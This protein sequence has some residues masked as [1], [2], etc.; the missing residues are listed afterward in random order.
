MKEVS[1]NELVPGTMYYIQSERRISGNGK[2][3]GVFT[4]IVQNCPECVKWCLF[5]N[6]K[7]VV[8]R[9]GYPYGPD[10]NEYYNNVKI[11]TFYLPENKI[12]EEQFL[13]NSV[14]KKITGDPCFTFY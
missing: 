11:N 14:L 7:D 1:A 6:V 10:D 4:R 5:K 8:G 9:S 3:K 13:V 12:I 2:Q